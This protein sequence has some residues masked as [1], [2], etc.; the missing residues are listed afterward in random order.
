MII[1]KSA[2]R[3]TVTHPAYP[4]ALTYILNPPNHP[5]INPSLEGTSQIPKIPL[6]LLFP[7]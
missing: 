5:F 4:Y 3:R 1:V 6:P 7:N 2:K